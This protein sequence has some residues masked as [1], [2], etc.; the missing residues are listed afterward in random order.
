MRKSLL[1]AGARLVFCALVAAPAIVL[2]AQA[3]TDPASRALPNPAPVV[4]KAWGTL[5]GGR[6]WGSSAGVDIGPDG[7]VW[8]YDRCGATALTGG[9]D[10]NDVDPIIKFDRETGNVLAS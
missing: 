6:S 9:C 5:P 4:T 7:H 2:V 8:A 10:E 1:S 3:P